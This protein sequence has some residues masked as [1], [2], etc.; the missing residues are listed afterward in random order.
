[1]PVVTTVRAAP[2]ARHAR[3]P[4]LPDRGPPGRLTA[5]PY[6]NPGTTPRMPADLAT[7]LAVEALLLA[8]AAACGGAA[9]TIPLAVAASVVGFVDL[10]PAAL[11][12]LLPAFVWLALAR[13]TGDR[14]LYFPFV[15]L[16]AGHVA[17]LRA[18]GRGWLGATGAIAVVVAFLAIRAGQGAT[19]RVLVV[20]AL[21][22]GAILVA[23]AI[24]VRIAP[25]S[26]PG[27]RVGAMAIAALAS[28]LALAGLSL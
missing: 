16:L 27:S 12:A 1:M 15:M 20:E 13:T 6:T 3:R 25:R 9:W 4:L 18:P 10:R 26:L 22:A 14:E 19:S 8:A 24:V 17:A 23:V 7:F 21:V 2:S 11:V 5:P 28:L